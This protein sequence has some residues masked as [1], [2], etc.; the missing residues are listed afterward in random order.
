MSV[1]RDTRHFAGCSD[2]NPLPVEATRSQNGFVGVIPEVPRLG[3]LVN[4]LAD[5]PHVVQGQ[6]VVP[7]RPRR[8]GL[9]VGGLQAGQ[10]PT[11]FLKPFGRMVWKSP[12]WGRGIRAV[13][14]GLFS[15]RRL[16]SLRGRREYNPPDPRA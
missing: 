14:G 8:A 4:G 10:L 2:D 9:P 3:H 13:T 7:A 6:R 16:A 15:V 11:P 5:E 1:S 12:L